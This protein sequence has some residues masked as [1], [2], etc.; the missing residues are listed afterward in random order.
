MKSP[1][2]W[3]LPALI[4]MIAPISV[5]AA[6]APFG[7]H[8][9]ITRNEADKELPKNYEWR[10][11]EDMTVRRVWKNEAET[12]MADFRPRT[13]QCLFISLAYPRPL[14]REEALRRASR[15]A[16]GEKLEPVRLKEAKR[17]QLQMM[18]ADVAKLKDGSYLFLEK[19]TGGR[20]ARISWYKQPPDSTRL[21]LQEA[22]DEGRTALGSRAD[23]GM[24]TVLKSEEARRQ[25]LPAH[26]DSGGESPSIPPGAAARHSS[27]EAARHTPAERTAEHPAQQQQNTPAPA[28]KERT[29]M[30]T[31]RM[32]DVLGYLRVMDPLYWAG[33]GAALLLLVTWFF[34]SSH[35]KRS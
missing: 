24:L 35:R 4:P 22:V 6:D 2:P 19:K 18:P 17:T 33:I 10:I 25:A 29:E 11:L 30:D 14:S 1:L 3:L 27:D 15:L 12:A 5:T 20:I 8:T 23:A 26:R 9:K 31:S 7:L 13:D 34:A 32:K 21:N 28:A 16:G